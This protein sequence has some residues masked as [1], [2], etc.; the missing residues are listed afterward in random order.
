MIKN[1]YFVYTETILGFPVSSPYAKQTRFY[2]VKNQSIN[3]T[4][5]SVF[6]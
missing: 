2:T 5:I 3:K 4:L 1:I 6:V